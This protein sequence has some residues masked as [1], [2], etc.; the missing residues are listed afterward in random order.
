M[1]FMDAGQ[2]DMPSEVMEAMP[3]EILDEYSLPKMDLH[4]IQALQLLDR[5]PGKFVYSFAEPVHLK[6]LL[7]SIPSS[8]KV[9][10]VSEELEGAWRPARAEG[11]GP[12][13]TQVDDLLE[14]YPDMA[15]LCR[16]EPAKS[17]APASEPLIAE[18]EAVPVGVFEGWEE[19][20]N[21]RAAVHLDPASRHDDFELV[22]PGG[23]WTELNKG[24]AFNVTRGQAKAGEPRRWIER[25]FFRHSA[26]HSVDKYGLDGSL[27]LTNAWL[28]R[29]QQLYDLFVA[30]GVP[31]Y[32][33]SAEEVAQVTHSVETIAACEAAA[34]PGRLDVVRNRLAQIEA[35]FPVL[36]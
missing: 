12:A 6:V 30:A 15:K 34:L 22:I 28:R 3:F 24:A 18:D 36:Q 8:R 27:Q 23:G 1:D 9:A 26:S 21:M 2:R 14:R 10:E 25:Y 17:N 16:D 20:A 31:E 35:L 29:M 13:P 19:L 7:D 4:Q 11:G 33:Y 32:V 5:M